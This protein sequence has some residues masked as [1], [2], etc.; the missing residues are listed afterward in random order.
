MGLGNGLAGE[1]SLAAGD[2]RTRRAMWLLAGLVVLAL[3]LRL[4]HLGAWGL[5]GDEIF[6]LRDSREPR[7]SN[8]RPLLY[9]LNY[10]LIRP[11]FGLNELGLRILPAF[12]GV[13]AIPTVYFVGR[14]LVGSR[15]ALFAALLVAL[16]PIHIYQS[17]YARYWSLVFLLSAAYPFAIHFG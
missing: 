8:P 16:S 14:R 9:L 15:A 11:T 13:L 5:E 4:W 2:Q 10:L 3:I 1:P 12:F 7:L 17:Q 6:T